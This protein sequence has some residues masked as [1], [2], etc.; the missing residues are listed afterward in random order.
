MD[1]NTA[2][3]DVIKGW[4][5]SELLVAWNEYCDVNGYSDNII[6]SID[7]FNECF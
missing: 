6:Y 7:S 4:S 2:I 5:D 1:K 3:S